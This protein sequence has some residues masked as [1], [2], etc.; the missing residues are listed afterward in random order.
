V[1]VKQRLNA[2]G[3]YNPR[4]PDDT[5]ALI[6]E[7]ARLMP[8][9]Q[10]ARLL[11][12]I[13]I[14]TGHGNAWTQERVRGFR[15]HHEIAGHRDGEWAERGEITLEAAA[16]IVGVCNMTALRMLRRGDIKGRQVCPGAPWVIKTAERPDCDGQALCGKDQL[17]RRHRPEDRQAG[18]LR[19][20][21]RRPGLF[22]QAELH[23]GG[24]DQAAVP[25]ADRRQQLFPPSYSRRT[26]LLYIPA[27]TMC[28]DSTLDQ[29]A[30]KK[31]IF[32]SRISKQIERNESDIVMADPLTGEVKKRVHSIYPNTSGVLTTGGGL[33]FTAYTDGTLAAYDDTTLDQVWK[34]NVGVGFNAPPMTFE[35]GGKQYVAILSGISNITKGRHVLTPELREMRNQTMLFVF[36]L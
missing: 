7:L 9:R 35:A 12:R 1:Q 34:V 3:R 11:N 16:K 18:G 14:A 2:A 26:G 20:K 5:I 32:F 28:N 25:G 13:R 27:F 10:I 31:G 33:V 6:R 17:D 21:S 8:D 36:G 15:N 23:P 24:A 29:E 19:S 30:I 22:G 4:V